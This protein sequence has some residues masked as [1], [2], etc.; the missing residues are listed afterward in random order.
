MFGFASF[1]RSVWAAAAPSSETVGS[2]LQPIHQQEP[3]TLSASVELEDIIDEYDEPSGKSRN[4]SVLSFPNWVQ[5]SQSYFSLSGTKDDETT[6][7]YSALQDGFSLDEYELRNKYGQEFLWNNSREKDVMLQR[8]NFQVSWSNLTYKIKPKPSIG[9]LW[10]ELSHRL[11]LRPL[12]KIIYR[13]KSK[14]YTCNEGGEQYPGARQPVT[15]L[16]HINGYFR[17]GELTGILGPSGAGKT[18]LLNILSRRRE[19]GFTGHLCVNGSDHRVR[20]NSIPQHDHLPEYLTVREN[21]TFASRLKNPNPD[22]DHEKNVQ[23][24]SNLLGLD[25]CLDTRTKKI[26]GGQLKRLAIAQELLSKPDILILDEPT[27]GLD[28]MTCLKTLMVLKDIK[29]SAKKIIDPMAIVLTIHQPQHEAFDLFDKVYVMASGG[30]VIYHGAPEKCTEFVETYAGIRM[31]SQDYNPASFL[32]EIASGEFGQEPID[33]L[34]R[35]VRLEFEREHDSCPSSA[36]QFV[37]TLPIEKDTPQFS[38]P[39]GSRNCGIDRISLQSETPRLESPLYLDPGLAKGSSMNEGHFFIRTM[40]LTQRC[41]VSYLRDSKQMAARILFHILLPFGMAFMMGIEPGRSNACPNFSPEYALNKIISSDE[42][43][44][45]NVQEE[46]LL[47]LENIG[48]LFITIYSCISANIAV[49]TLIF[50]ID[51]QSSLKEFYNGWYSMNSYIIARLLSN[52]PLDIMLPTATIALAY[53]FT[54]QNTGQGSLSDTYRIIITALAV[55][56]SS[57]IGQMMGMIFGAIYVGHITTALFASQGATLP[58]VLLSGFVARL[59]NMSKFVRVMSMTSFYRH[60]LEVT[61]IARYG[62]NVCA[63]DRS[64]VDGRE[65]V[66]TG[67]S[68]DLESFIKYW[69]NTQREQQNY[70][71]TVED[72]NMFQLIAK[73]V[74][75]YNTYGVDIK[76]CNQ[77]VPFQLHEFGLTE[78]DLPNSFL[79]LFISLLTMMLLLFI[80]VKLLITYRTS[81]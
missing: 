46:L 37:Q 56:L 53:V 17:S 52:I 73:Q 66:M 38:T 9:E 63:C 72:E 24:V 30:R 77:V 25:Q 2:Y 20:I 58:F 74:S 81:L 39:H 26:S 49:M 8:S 70:N 5:P 14:S 48:V 1:L 23:R 50:T 16:Q 51:M 18:S 55:I 11:T 31:P 64:K 60:C 33:A 21:L 42:Y 76:S 22:Q 44:N 32:V 35:Q 68:E 13:T 29:A 75:L 80:I 40:I 47:T 69:T 67:V 45:P 28:S 62:Y 12:T 15:I 19:E 61:F 59:K 78:S 43:I 6:S 10:S 79:A 7:F 57:S 71:S 27:S 65:V 34:E 3:E 4:T 36:N 54:G 41:W